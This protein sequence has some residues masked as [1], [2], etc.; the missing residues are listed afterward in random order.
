MTLIRGNY[1]REGQNRGLGV[2]PLPQH[3]EISSDVVNRLSHP[4]YW[5]PFILIGNG[6]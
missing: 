1:S 5:A 2:V 4:Y 3:L 6:F